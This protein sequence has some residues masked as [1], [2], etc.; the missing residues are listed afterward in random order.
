MGNKMQKQM[1]TNNLL[2]DIYQDSEQALIRG[3]IKQI[4]KTTDNIP[5]VITFTCLLFYCIQEKFTKHGECM[6]LQEIPLSVSPSLASYNVVKMRRTGSGTAYGNVTIKP[7]GKYIY[8]WQVKVI[9]INYRYPCNYSF[10][11][12]SSNKK[13]CNVHFREGGYKI[14]RTNFGNT[15]VFYAYG[16]NGNNPN[17]GFKYSSTLPWIGEE[18]GEPIGLNDTVGIILNGLDKTIEFV[19]N[20][21]SL[22]VAFNDIDCEKQYHFAISISSRGFGEMKLLQFQQTFKKQ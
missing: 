19:R 17:K 13:Y 3:F 14:N 11:I 1:A 9:E 12:E 5:T 10:G 7:N 22:G 20:N 15:H 18:Y 8:K 4:Y 6:K 16:S 2:I 21:K